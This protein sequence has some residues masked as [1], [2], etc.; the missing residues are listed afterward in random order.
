MSHPVVNDLRAL[1]AGLIAD[2]RAASSG[3]ASRTIFGGNGE[4]LHQTLVALAGGRGLASHTN[5]GQATVLILLGAA[6]LLGG[7]V[8]SVV[9]R[10]SP[11]AAAPA[12]AW[13]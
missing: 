4:T 5:P 10:C 13:W 1:A 8:V 6:T 3:R 2:A 9:H 11:V 7:P 12:S